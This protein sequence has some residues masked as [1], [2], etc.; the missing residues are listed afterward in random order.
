MAQPFVLLHV[1]DYVGSACQLARGRFSEASYRTMRR[2]TSVNRRRPQL[3]SPGTGTRGH[4]FDATDGGADRLGRRGVGPALFRI[5]TRASWPHGTLF[6]SSPRAAAQG[7]P[8][9]RPSP[10]DRQRQEGRLALAGRGLKRE[11]DVQQAEGG[12]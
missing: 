12:L 9:V 8:P 1:P 5:A 10:A 4:S 2:A 6:R 7:I 3:R 11:E